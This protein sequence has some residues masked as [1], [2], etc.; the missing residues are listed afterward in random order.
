M[1][2]Q[3]VKDFIAQRRAVISE[4]D[5]STLVAILDRM[6]EKE[7]PQLVEES[8]RLKVLGNSAYER[9]NLEEALALYTQAIEAYPLNAPVYSNRALIYSKLNRDSEGIADCLAGIKIDP[10][11]TKFYVRLGTM[12]LKTDRKKASHYFKEGLARDP[13]NEYLQSLA[14]STEEEEDKS[15]VMSNL[16]QYLQ[17]DSVQNAVKD[18]M[19]DKSAADIADMFRSAFPKS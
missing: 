11:F 8:N 3:A 13:D 12:Y 16:A 7:R 6:A 14:K 2:Y 15:S 18:F 5:H 9:G 17:S 19:K 10:D 4:E 1:N